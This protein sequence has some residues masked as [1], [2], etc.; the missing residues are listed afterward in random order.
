MSKAL[1]KKSILQKTVHVATSTLLSRILGIIREILTVKYMG[2]SAL[3]DAFVTAFKIPNSLRKV[4]AEGALSA[5][6]IPTLVGLVRSHDKNGINS[7]MTLTFIF[8]EGIVVF[9][10]ALVMLFPSATIFLIAP[11]FSA[12]QNALT[13]PYLLILMP[14]I[15][16][17]SSSAVLACTLNSVGHF[18]VPAF[19]SVL[20]NIFFI[21]GLLLGIFY[22]YSIEF[23]CYI[24]MISGLV[25]LIIHILVYVRYQFSFGAITRQTLTDFKKI[26]I[27]FLPCMIA[28]SMTELLLFI[29]TSFAS[30]LPTGSITLIKYANRFM[31]IPL[32]VFGVAFSTILL[33]HFSRVST[34]APKRLNFYLLEATKLIFWVT[35]PIMLIMIYF[36]YEIFATIFLSDKF[37]VAQA[38]EAGKIMNGF[39][40]GLFFFSVNK[41]LLNM[42][43]ALHNTWIP[44]V[45]SIGATIVNILFNFLLMPFFGATGLA[46]A[47]SIA[48]AFQTGAFL[49]LLYQHFNFVIHIRPFVDFLIKLCMQLTVVLAL[50][51]LLFHLI[52]N[53][54]YYLPGAWPHL[55]H[56]TILY[57]VWV[58]PLAAIIFGLMY[59]TRKRFGVAMYFLD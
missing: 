21:A 2:V 40:V 20:L 3:S 16:F 23:L 45:V 44:T 18:F 46:V 57:W 50:S 37:S 26:M 8:F 30:F 9:L 34:Y 32:G 13:V 11:G 55:L 56:D 6:L 27:K 51:L 38:H 4:F 54:I 39:M 14:F 15:F 35:I 22:N 53:A 41:I 19:S 24:I 31:G 52:N 7:L 42:F 48:G 49:W 29:D 10:C 12:S 33:P 47:T 25:Q 59:V 28:M 1:S 36:S 17:L 43:Y 58:G 5:A